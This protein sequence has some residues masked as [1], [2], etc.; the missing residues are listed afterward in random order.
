[1]AA[2]LLLAA[3]ACGGDERPDVLLVTVDTL[4]AD[5]VS[6]LGYPRPTTPHLDRLAAEG[7]LFARHYTTSSQTGPA[8]ASLFSGLMPGEHGLVKNGVPVP[9]AM[10]WVPEEFARAGWSTGAAVG[11]VVVGRRFGFERGF[12]HF[13]EPGQG[14]RDTSAAQVLERPAGQV[15]DRAS[16]WLRGVG[17][18]PVFL[19]VHVF[20]PHE[21]YQPPVPAPLSPAGAGA[22]FRARGEASAFFEPAQLA[23]MLAGYE[24][25]VSYTDRELGRLF[26]EFDARDRDSI[27]VITSD[28]GE[29]LGEHGYQGH[30]LYLYEEQAHVPLILR[31]R[32]APAALFPAG[33]RVESVTSAVEVAEALRLW[34]DLPS[35]GARTSLPA[36]IRAPG[37]D[38]AARALLERAHLT[39]FDLEHVPAIRRTLAARVGSAGGARGPLWALVG[40]EH[41]WIEADEGTDELYDLVADPREAHNL[42]DPD[43]RRAVS[44]ELAARRAALRTAPS[45]AEHEVDEETLRQLRALGY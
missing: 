14:D 29:G 40:P 11:A 13:D 3:A 20:D 5:Y 2:L 21:P 34:A 24:A 18:G 30:H 38:P 9:A 43:L 10:P 22:F 6:A 27:T 16:A 36:R 4:R 41:K 17:P 15:V 12:G 44:A 39:D 8:H 31:G 37:P 35:A 32:G 28:H 33:T 42:A 1:M 23:T 45:T 26:A 19:W 25:E 7:V